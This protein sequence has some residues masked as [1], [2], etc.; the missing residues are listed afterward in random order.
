VQVAFQTVLTPDLNEM[1]KV[2][3]SKVLLTEIKMLCI[4]HLVLQILSL[5]PNFCRIQSITIFY[6]L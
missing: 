6:R 5:K 2:Y 3:N 1:A 4:K